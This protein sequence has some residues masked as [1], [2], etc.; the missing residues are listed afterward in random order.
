MRKVTLIVSTGAAGVFDFEL[1]RLTSPTVPATGNPVIIPALNDLAQA[2]TVEATCLALP[3]TAGTLFAAD[4]PLG[5]PVT[6]NSAAAAA[7]ANPHG[8]DGERIVLYQ[9]DDT[10]NTQPIA[11]YPGSIGGFAINGR[12]TAAVALRF[13]VAIEF[14][15]E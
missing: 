6:W 4:S 1:R 10:S 9:Y 14:T 13:M 2:T 15:E 12:C 7:V 8:L 5:V 3:T 11:A